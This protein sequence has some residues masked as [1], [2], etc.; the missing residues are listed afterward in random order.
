MGI[1]WE[2]PGYVDLPLLIGS[3]TGVQ[4]H[5]SWLGIKNRLAL[6][7]LDLTEHGGMLQN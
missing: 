3:E 1:S 4:C 5:T 6:A 7:R 2:F